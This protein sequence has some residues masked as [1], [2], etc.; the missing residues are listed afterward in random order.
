MWRGRGPGTARQDPWGPLTYNKVNCIGTVCPRSCD[1]FD[2]VTYY[3]SIY[4]GLHLKPPLSRRQDVWRGRGPGAA[5]Q[6]RLFQSQHR[7]AQKVSTHIDFSCV[8]ILKNGFHKMHF[9]FFFNNRNSIDEPY[10]NIRMH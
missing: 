8:I 2:K 1:P 9:T 6:V 4:I 3:I 5:R 7:H 10:H